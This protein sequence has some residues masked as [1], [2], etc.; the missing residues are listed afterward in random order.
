MASAPAAKTPEQRGDSGGGDSGGYYAEKAAAAAAS[1]A[2]LAAA[3]AAA[4]ARTSPMVDGESGKTIDMLA[5]SV[6]PSDGGR[7]NSELPAP[8]SPV[9][10]NKFSVAVPEGGSGGGGGRTGEFSPKMAGAQAAAVAAVGVPALASAST[11]REKNEIAAAGLLLYGARGQGGT[12]ASTGS[13][14]AIGNGKI[15]EG[16]ENN[17]QQQQQMTM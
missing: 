15:E 11:E 4:I 16:R 2:A 9:R 13:T 10:S 6:A 14:G 17:F 3:V 5:C 12:G 1:S 8:L 7:S